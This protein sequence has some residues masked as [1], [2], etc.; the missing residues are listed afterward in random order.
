[1]TRLVLVHSS[2]SHKEAPGAPHWASQ[3]AAA[4]LTAAQKKWAAAQAAHQ[5]PAGQALRLVE[6]E[7]RRREKRRPLVLFHANKRRA[8]KLQRTPSW[9]DMAAIK[10]FYVEARRLTVATGIP[11][12]VDHEIP[13]QGRL[14]SGLHVHTNLQILTGSENSKKRNRFDPEQHPCQSNQS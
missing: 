9:A 11:H 6:E 7:R 8:S 1:M 2:D 3:R 5:S 12:H 14:V 10:A 4:L 13:L